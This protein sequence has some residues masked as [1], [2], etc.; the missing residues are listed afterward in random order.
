MG[1]LNNGSI[2]R[3]NMRIDPKL[4]RGLEEYRR[5]NG[6]DYWSITQKDKSLSKFGRRDTLTTSKTTIADFDTGNSILSEN[7]LTTNGITHISSSN[8]TTDIG[9]IIKIE[10]HTIN[11]GGDELTFGVQSV[12]LNGQ[13]IVPLPVPAAR[14]SRMYNS[15]GTELV[16]NIYAHEGNVT[17]GVPVPGE[18]HA[19]ISAG[20]Q[21]TTKCA[22]SIS[23]V[24]IMLITSVTTSVL[25]IQGATNLEA[26]LIIETKALDGV[27]LPKFE[28]ACSNSG[29]AAFHIDVDPVIIVP[30]NHDIRIVGKTTSG[31][32]TVTAS[33]GGYLAIL[34]SR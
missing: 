19:R 9:Q 25:D 31:T 24:D 7:L 33:F 2:I 21:Q 3:D 5:F 28:W 16:G 15:S 11:A 34:D 26:V 27:W 18:I 22:T 8:N 14:V 17:A 20:Y 13:T 10:Y 6:G 29:T 4:L 30:Q 1:Q 32:A 12:A 23:N